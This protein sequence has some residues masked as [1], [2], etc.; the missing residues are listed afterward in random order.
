MKTKQ[1]LKTKGLYIKKKVIKRKKKK[2][3]IKEG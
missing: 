2:K 3:Q 1:K